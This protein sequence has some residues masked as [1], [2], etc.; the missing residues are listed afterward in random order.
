MDSKLGVLFSR[1]RKRS[2][3]FGP[4]SHA[5][6][7]RKRQYPLIFSYKSS[8]QVIYFLRNIS[9]DSIAKSNLCGSSRPVQPRP[10]FVHLTLNGR[11]AAED[12]ASLTKDIA[13]CLADIAAKRGRPFN[14]DP[15]LYHISGCQ[16][17]V[18]QVDSNNKMI[19]VAEKAPVPKADEETSEAEKAEAGG[20]TSEPTTTNTR[21]VAD[22]APVPKADEETSEA[23]KSEVGGET[24]EP[25][26]TSTRN[27]AEKAEGD[28]ETSEATAT[29]TRKLPR[30]H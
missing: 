7:N 30:L 9:G 21:N 11:T 8:N 10:R 28:G 13:T 18:N 25:T 22:K 1:A 23:E 5:T 3:E 14:A 12:W 4:F 17:A 6:L 16:P 29:T 26:T 15:Y 27:D 2:L 20:E 24:S 19:N